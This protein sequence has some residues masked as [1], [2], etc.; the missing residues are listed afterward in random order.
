M[1]EEFKEPNEA[2]NQKQ[3]IKKPLKIKPAEH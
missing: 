2:L 3:A 1:D